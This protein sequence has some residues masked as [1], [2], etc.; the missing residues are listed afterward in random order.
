MRVAVILS[1]ALL[2]LGIALEVIAM[3][4][5]LTVASSYLALFSVLAGALVL[6]IV[7]VDALLPNASQR[8]DGCQH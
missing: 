4:T 7:F 5:T 1:A 6:A 2:A 3:S 8:L